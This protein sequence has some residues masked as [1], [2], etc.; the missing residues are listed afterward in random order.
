MAEALLR[1]ALGGQSDITVESA[2]LHAL[3][4]EPAA[5]HAVSLLQARD[6]D[7]SGHRAQQLT[8]GLI[9]RADLVLVMEAQH[10][11]VIDTNEPIARGKVY[12]LGEW[13]KIEVPDPYR[14]SKD[15]FAESLELIDRGVADWVE[16]IV[17]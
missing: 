10:K 12:R 15:A 11:R 7:I 3:V 4:G 2:G 16:R 9:S 6:I 5:E 1:S 13:R 8:A 17:K 14:K